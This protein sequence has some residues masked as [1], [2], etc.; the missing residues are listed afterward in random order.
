MLAPRIIHLCL[1]V[2]LYDIEGFPENGNYQFCQ[3]QKEI[4]GKNGG[5]MDFILAKP[6]PVTAATR[7][8]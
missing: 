6:A 5:R 3:H 4:L 7:L 2:R 1:R 8:S